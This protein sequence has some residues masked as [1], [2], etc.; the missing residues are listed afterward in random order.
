MEESWYCVSFLKEM[1]VGYF[2]IHIYKK[3]NNMLL[4][5]FLAS[6]HWILSL[7]LLKNA[8]PKLVIV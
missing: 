7:E 2:F 5:Y 4:S 6:L 8:E 1:L 3:T